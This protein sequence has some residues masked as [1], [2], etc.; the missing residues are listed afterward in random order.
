MFDPSLSMPHCIFSAMEGS[1]SIAECN[2]LIFVSNHGP[3]SRALFNKLT[4]PGPFQCWAACNSS[5]VT[6][7]IWTNETYN[8]KRILSLISKTLFNPCNL[9]I[10]EFCFSDMQCFYSRET[11]NRPTY[12]YANSGFLYVRHRGVSK[13][14]VVASP[15]PSRSEWYDRFRRPTERAKKRGHPAS[16]CSRNWK[17]IWPIAASHSP[18]MWA[19]SSR[20]FRGRA[21][22]L[23]R[24]QI[25]WDDLDH[26]WD[27]TD[28]RRVDRTI[29]SC[30]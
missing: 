27:V 26:V 18:A 12:E 17:H 25:R 20:P 13:S 9:T 8:N 2:L 5:E 24:I 11:E 28:H 30:V 21:G 7:T 6:P 19:A 23:T 15:V 14:L 10:I 4:T 16:A 3:Q 29:L 1:S 22:K